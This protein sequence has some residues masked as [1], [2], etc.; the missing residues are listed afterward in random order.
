MATQ[1]K[2]TFA[3]ELYGVLPSLVALIC[4]SII[5]N[6]PLWGW[7]SILLLLVVAVGAFALSRSVPL[8]LVLAFVILDKGLF[9]HPFVSYIGAVLLSA[10]LLLLAEESRHR[11]L[12]N[13]ILMLLAIGL[14]PTLY[15]QHTGLFSLVIGVGAALG[16]GLLLATGRKLHFMTNPLTHLTTS[17]HVNRYRFSVFCIAFLSFGSLTWGYIV[18]T[19]P[20]PGLSAIA[21]L[22]LSLVSVSVILSV[23]G[24]DADVPDSQVAELSSHKER[25]IAELAEK[26]KQLTE[27]HSVSTAIQTQHSTQLEQA[28]QDLARTSRQIEMQIIQANQELEEALALRKRKA[29]AE[30]E[31]AYYQQPWDTLVAHLCNKKTVAIPGGPTLSTTDHLLLGVRSSSD[32][33]QEHSWDPVFLPKEILH[34]HVH[35]LGGTGSGKTSLGITPVAIQLLRQN[36]PSPIIFLDLKGDAATFH[37]AREEAERNNQDF[38]FFTIESNK[39]TFRFNPFVGIKSF[40]G[41]RNEQAQP[42]LDALGLNHG[43]GYGRSFFTRINRQRMLE[44]LEKNPNIHTFA[45]LKEALGSGQ[46]AKSARRPVPVTSQKD[47]LIAAIE[48]ISDYPQLFTT[49]EEEQSGSGIIQFDKVFEKNQVVYFWIPAPTQS[50]SAREVGKLVLYNLFF[51]ALKRKNNGQRKQ[52]Y[53]FIDEFQ[54]IVG[55]NLALLLEQSRSYGISLVLVNQNIEQLNSHDVRLWPL[56]QSNVRA[57]LHFG[58][59]DP[60]EVELLSKASGEMISTL[61]AFSKGSASG[62]SRGLSRTKTDGQTLTNTWGD[63]ETTGYSAG[64]SKRFGDFITSTISSQTSSA[65][66]SSNSESISSSL[67]EGQS[68][69]SSESTSNETTHTEYMRPRLRPED[70]ASVF[71]KANHFLY[72]VR[73][74]VPPLVDF[75]GKP[76]EVRGI[77][78]V[79]KHLHERRE[80]APWPVLPSIQGHVVRTPA[81]YKESRVVTE[82]SMV[83]EFIDSLKEPY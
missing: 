70:I 15:P 63:S 36:P 20:T 53:L 56:V 27:L 14:G 79:P 33:V 59:G 80:N 17:H 18:Q 9:H 72:W 8:L 38:L 37:T 74:G 68:D 39:A 65:D 62:S 29:A 64:E 83:K 13:I 2:E 48:G 81:Q 16:L 34:E 58:S 50:I 66:S 6:A 22:A 61:A 12:F 51:A 23:F 52:V 45:Q 41:T 4:L 28:Y 73:R 69:S 21:H 82:Q 26:E 75:D 31:T 25:L 10:H 19:F 78:A 71:N 7:P 30:L 49:P 24:L 54:R 67:S 77:Y 11:V 42:L 46:G 60:K 76:V 43:E 3:L 40:G 47:E 44:A 35:I 5:R 1:N 32:A 57:S 55:E